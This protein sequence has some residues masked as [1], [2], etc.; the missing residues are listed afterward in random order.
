MGMKGIR[1]RFGRATVSFVVVATGLLSTVGSTEG[2][3]KAAA[4]PVVAAAAPASAALWTYNASLHSEAGTQ[5]PAVCV[6]PPAGCAVPAPQAETEPWDVP[7]AAQDFVA[8]DGVNVY[9]VSSIHTSYNSS[10]NT[11]VFPVW[12][13]PIVGYGSGCVSF[14]LNLSTLYTYQGIISVD[15]A[16]DT[17]GVV[18][19]PGA[20]YLFIGFVGD[21][22]GTIARCPVAD[23]GSVTCTR[24]ESSGGRG[25]A[26]MVVANGYLWVALQ[27]S[28]SLAN[29]LLWRCGLWTNDDCQVFDDPKG[30]DLLSLEVGG[31][32]LWAGRSDGVIWRCDMT[33]ANRC[34]V[35]DTAASVRIEALSYDGAGTLYATVQ[36][37]KHNKG[38][39]WSCSTAHANG[40]L[41]VPSDTGAGEMR[42]ALNVEAGG[43][44]VFNVSGVPDTNP[45]LNFGT[46]PLSPR[47][48]SAAS[49]SLLYVPAGGLA[50]QGAARIGLPDLTGRLAKVGELCAR[51]GKVWADLTVTGPYGVR[52]D[53]RVDVCAPNAAGWSFGS[54][55]AGR[56]SASLRVHQFV[57]RGSATVTGGGVTALSFGAPA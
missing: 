8:S 3:S 55:D 19:Q 27:G 46:L 2:V 56:Y 7:P 37:N 53:R 22:Q 17:A 15:V 29:G 14:N 21:S 45:R 41:T 36:S 6:D 49:M 30:P 13:C 47:S 12:S 54:L 42:Y 1:G 33:A 40:C 51:A 50:P 11:G 39:V 43:G 34:A 9:A 25:A 20:T 52:F 10:N 57:L 35:W 44:G 18:G 26:G 31:G 5:A 23:S 32:Y 4:A 38:L 24:H 16:V 48:N 28:G